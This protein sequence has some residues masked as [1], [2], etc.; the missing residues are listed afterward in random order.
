MS[1]M[2]IQGMAC[3]LG[4]RNLRVLHKCWMRIKVPE[5]KSCED[6]RKYRGPNSLSVTM[7]DKISTPIIQPNS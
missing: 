6:S 1:Y 3:G 4:S 2:H 7:W 5:N